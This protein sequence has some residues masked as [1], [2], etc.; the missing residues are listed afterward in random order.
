MDISLLG[1]ILFII[2]L[3]ILIVGDNIGKDELGI[4][5]GLLGLVGAGIFTHFLK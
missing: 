3:V 1:C 2:G 5:G 4:F